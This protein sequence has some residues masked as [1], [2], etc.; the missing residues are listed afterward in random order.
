MLD[1]FTHAICSFRIVQ[2]KAVSNVFM[3]IAHWFGMVCLVS[4]LQIIT[5]KSQ[6]VTVIPFKSMW[7]AWLR[8]DGGCFFE[9]I[10]FCNYNGYRTFSPPYPFS[11]TSLPTTKNNP[12]ALVIRGWGTFFKGVGW[13]ANASEHTCI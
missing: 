10:F 12:T 1:I 9:R 8:G 11:K 13:Y 3:L 2:S 6:Y 5:N 7:Y 4:I